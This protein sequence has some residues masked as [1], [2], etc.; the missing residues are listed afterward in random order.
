MPKS[1]RGSYQLQFA[2]ETRDDDISGLYTRWFPNEQDYRATFNS[3]T[4][5]EEETGAA[6]WVEI[7]NN[8]FEE[9][10]ALAMCAEI[11][12]LVSLAVTLL[13]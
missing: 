13:I 3:T 8:Y 5:I 1:T 11:A 4:K 6:Y 9:G 7:P 10:G 12:L 2:Y